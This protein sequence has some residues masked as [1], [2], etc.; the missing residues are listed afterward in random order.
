MPSPNL[1][2]ANTVVNVSQV[3]HLSPFRYPGGK[4]WLVPRVRAWL[5]SFAEPIDTF[6]E[7]FCG[8]AI[9]GLSVA[10]ERLA[11]SVTLVELDPKVAA[12]WQTIFSGSD[13]D[14]E[15]FCDLIT[16]LDLTRATAEEI[17]GESNL[18]TVHLAFQTIVRNRVSHGG[19]L[20]QGTGIL[21]NGEKGK[22]ILS[23]WYPK[24]LVTRIRL[25]RLMRD[26]VSFVQDDALPFLSRTQSQGSSDWAFF[27]DPPYLVPG[28]RLYDFSEVDHPRLFE[29][30]S[31]LPGQVLLT[32]DN[33]ARV[34]DLAKKFGMPTR[35]IAMQN[36]NHTEQKEL[37]ISRDFSWLKS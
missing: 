19:G 36:K 31:K 33:D 25:I 15:H 22:G 16:Q 29:L 17:L 14:V 12:V 35:K 27:M 9:V 23:R 30:A 32:Y 6:V 5:T 34:R 11:R 26:I 37:L 28:S 24:T 10:A 4:T 20:A 8:G 13:R 1:V 2:N 21:R 7:P 18:D 3:R